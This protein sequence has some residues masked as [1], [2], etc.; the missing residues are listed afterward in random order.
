M[1]IKERI[2]RFKLKQ[3]ILVAKGILAEIYSNADWN[4]NN[5]TV[6]DQLRANAL[7]TEIIKAESIL[8]AK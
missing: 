6:E 2:E 7:M 1:S 3:D 8:E 4:E 5:L